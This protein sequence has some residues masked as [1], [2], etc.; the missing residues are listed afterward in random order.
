[1]ATAGPGEAEA[2]GEDDTAGDGM[3]ATG[4]GTAGDGVEATGDGDG[5]TGS[6]DPQ[7]EAG[8]WSRSSDPPAKAEAAPRTLQ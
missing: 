7:P 8:G 1:M 5:Q 3:E 4:G 6:L 2:A